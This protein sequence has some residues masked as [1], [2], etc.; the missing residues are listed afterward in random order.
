MNA[1]AAVLSGCCTLQHSPQRL[2]EQTVVY[3]ND[4]GVTAWMGRTHHSRFL[5]FFLCKRP[6]S[7][8]YSP[9]SF[10]K[11]PGFM[12][13]NPPPPPPPTWPI[14]FGSKEPSTGGGSSR[15]FRPESVSTLSPS[16][17][18]SSSTV[19]EV[20]RANDPRLTPKGK[21]NAGWPAAAAAAGKGGGCW[22]RRSRTRLSS[23]GRRV[24]S[25]GSSKKLR[26][27]SRIGARSSAFTMKGSSE[28]ILLLVRMLLGIDKGAWVF[29]GDIWGGCCLIVMHVFS[30]EVNLEPRSVVEW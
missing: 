19:P 5:L 22:L 11:R 4:A 14:I 28:N 13:M 23:S 27:F 18:S 24:D 8:P 2:I 15:S 10:M 12:V 9:P 21:S 20:G 6:P 26:G 1:V 29:S 16:S 30:G 17:E 3:K 25:L 7:P